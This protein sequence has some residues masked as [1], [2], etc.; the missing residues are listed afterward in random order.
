MTNNIVART[1]SI[2]LKLSHLIMLY[3]IIPITI[4]VVWLDQTIFNKTILF[5][6]PF[7]PE[8]WILW[9]YLF[10]MPHVIGGMQMFADS[11]YLKMYGWRLFRILIVCLLLP[12][13]VVSLLGEQYMFMIFMTFI[14]YHTISQQFGLT[15][16][17]LKKKPD[18][19]FYVWKWF[20]I[21]VS[22][23]L[24]VLLYSEPFPLVLFDNG[25]R[26]PLVLT[27]KIF[28]VISI[29]A[30]SLIIWR[31]RFN[32]IGI[33]YVISNVALIFTECYLF[34]MQYY[35]LVVVI[36]RIIHEFTAWPIYAIHDHNRNYGGSPNWIFRLFRN[37]L[38]MAV[39][40]IFSA[41]LIGFA[42]MFTVSSI[43]F[44]ASIFVS[45]SIYHYYTEHFLWRRDGLLR[46]HVNFI[47]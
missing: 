25:L 3:W 35:F 32:K 45:L 19:L 41:F 11:E 36:G 30:A 4:L 31:N 47:R 38:P 28:L 42:L 15:L 24:Y 6:S 16:V 23:I 10:G 27:G 44:L 33:L 46:N 39:L 37:K 5:S 7:R 2:G 20:A 14:V 17:A 18:F 29:L 22:M 26:D 21:G 1:N 40:S 8:S 9:V 13:V 12:P 34:Y 43:P